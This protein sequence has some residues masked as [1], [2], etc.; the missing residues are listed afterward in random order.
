MLLKNKVG[1]VTGGSSGMGS[2]M[3]RMFAEEGCSVAI[4]DIQTAKGEKIA[5]EISGKGGNA[6]F[7]QCDVTKEDQVQKMVDQVISKYGKVDILVNNAG[8]LPGA[9][10][11]RDYIENVSEE[12]WDEILDLNLKSVFLC[13]K[14][15]VPHM[16]TRKYGRIINISSIGAVQPVG[17]G[18]HYHTAKAGVLGLTHDLASQVAPFKILVNAILPGLIRTA[19]WDP[20]LTKIADKER[21]FAD[22]GRERLPLQTMGTP[23]E[24][25]GA[26]LFLASDLS[27]HVTGTHIYV[28]GGLPLAPFTGASAKITASKI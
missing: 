12:R 23:E 17:P 7:V 11:G 8:G 13:C 14:A 6:I 9:E 28:T 21:F 26:A 24:V 19:F 20:L 16:K 27:S 22:L 10:A 3:A 15:V 18:I 4:V 5:A 2:A 1:I 25:A